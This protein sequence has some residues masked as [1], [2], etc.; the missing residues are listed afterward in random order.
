MNKYFMYKNILSGATNIEDINLIRNIFPISDSAFINSIIKSKNMN[1]NKFSCVKFNEILNVLSKMH[2]IDECEKYLSEINFKNITDTLQCSFISDILQTK[3]RNMTYIDLP[4][5][6]KKC[7]HC[8]RIN[9]APLGTTY[10]V[11]GVD[12]F[13]K[14]AIDNFNDFC[15]KDWCFSC[16]KKLCKNWY[17]DDLYNPENRC[18][19]KICCATHAKKNNE[20][21]LN[22]YCQ[23]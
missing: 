3:K 20:D 1:N 19:N 11:C 23:C 14:N 13:G 10:I 21:Y 18:H 16:G 8:G 15:L 5:I 9:L 2:F 4:K 17:E 12:T 6:E 22:E 7:P